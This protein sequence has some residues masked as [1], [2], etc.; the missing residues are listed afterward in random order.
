[1]AEEIQITGT[2]EIGKVRHP[3]GPFGLSLLTLGFYYFF[4]YYKINKELAAIGQARN[5]P[6]LGDA[7]GTSLL[8]ITLGIFI[9]VPPYVS[10]YNTWKRLSEAEKVLGLP[11]SMN[12]AVGFILTLFIG[13]VGM[14]FLQTGLNNVLKAQA[15]A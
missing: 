6:Q 1:M 13:P 2:Q 12:P 8:A 7:P 3:L 15:Q 5:A 10:H 9:I 14:Y 4:W 11:E